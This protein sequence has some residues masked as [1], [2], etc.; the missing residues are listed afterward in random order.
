MHNSFDALA[1]SVAVGSMSRRESLRHLLRF[2]GTSAVASIAVACGRS[3]VAP[4]SAERFPEA[5]HR[6]VSPLVSQDLRS[7]GS[8]VV[9]VGSCDHAEYTKCFNR[10]LSTL[11][12]NVVAC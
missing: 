6:S 2:L 4:D 8:G 3:P 11:E 7:D 12:Q 5:D 9:P 10:A 1:K